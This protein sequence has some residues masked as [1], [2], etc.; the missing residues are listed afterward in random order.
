MPD[1]AAQPAS[2]TPGGDLPPALYANPPKTPPSS[3]QI[4]DPA[5]PHVEAPGNPRDGGPPQWMRARADTPPVSPPAASD[6]Q[7]ELYSRLLRVESKLDE[8]LSLLR[9]KA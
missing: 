4:A 9:R 2:A 6:L 3:A 5:S 8:V 7:G 1:P